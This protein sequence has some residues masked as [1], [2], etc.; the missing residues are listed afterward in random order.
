MFVNTFIRLLAFI[1]EK[2]DPEEGQDAEGDQGE[3]EGRDDGKPEENLGGDSPGSED[4]E[5]ALVWRYLSSAVIRASKLRRLT[6]LDLNVGLAQNIV[7]KL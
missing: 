7:T 4:Q 3:L 1:C 6:K 2:G 5:E